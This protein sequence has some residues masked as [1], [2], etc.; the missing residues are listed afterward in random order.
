MNVAL[1]ILVRFPVTA[2]EVERW[3][4]K[5]KRSHKKLSSF[6]N[7]K[8]FLLVWIVSIQKKGKFSLKWCK[9]IDSSKNPKK[10]YKPKAHLGLNKLSKTLKSIA[11][12][13]WAAVLIFCVLRINVKFSPFCSLFILSLFRSPIIFGAHSSKNWC[14]HGGSIVVSMF[15]LSFFRVSVT[16]PIFERWVLKGWL[17]YRYLRDEC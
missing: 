10:F 4:L 9:C 7:R 3:L 11:I 14:P 16:V 15:Q 13:W 8:C 6:D 1:K 17:Q 2:A 12:F 5:V